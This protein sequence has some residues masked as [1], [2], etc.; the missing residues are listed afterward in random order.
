[1]VGG[2]YGFVAK[3]GATLHHNMPESKLYGQ[4][5]ATLAAVITKTAKTRKSLR[6]RTVGWEVSKAT[7]L[8]V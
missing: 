5:N 8:F 3:T 2:S 7:C 1:M 4:K 6:R